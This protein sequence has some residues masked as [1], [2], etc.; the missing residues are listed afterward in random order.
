LAQDELAIRLEVFRRRR[1]R[2]N[3]ALADTRQEVDAC[4]AG[5][6]TPITPSGLAQLEILLMD[7]RELLQDLIVLDDRFTDYLAAS[8]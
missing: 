6:S 1:R 3:Q 7:R 5:I 8:R 2:L 4:I